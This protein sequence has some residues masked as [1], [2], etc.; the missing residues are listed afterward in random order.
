MLA[1][2]LE[3]LAVTE[4]ELA[5]EPIDCDAVVVEVDNVLLVPHSKYAVVDEPFGF[6]TPFSVA[7]VE[8]TFVAEL[9]VTVGAAVATDVV[10]LKELEYALVPPAFFALTRQ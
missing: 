9:V 8:P 10:K 5:P 6:T 7:E 4:T 1:L 2:R 3:R